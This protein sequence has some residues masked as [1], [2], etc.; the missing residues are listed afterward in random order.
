M[1]LHYFAESA[2]LKTA[3]ASLILPSGF[4]AD[5]LQAGRDALQSPKYTLCAGELILSSG[6]LPDVL[7]AICV[8]A[9]RWQD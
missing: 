6:F 1:Q 5:A 3:L 8:Y 4:L 2:S 7:Q 9:L